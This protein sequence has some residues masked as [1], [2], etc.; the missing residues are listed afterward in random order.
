[1]YIAIMPATAA[2]DATASPEITHTFFTQFTTR[3]R[4]KDAQEETDFSHYM[5]AGYNCVS[6]KQRQKVTT[7]GNLDNVLAIWLACCYVTNRPASSS[8]AAAPL[9]M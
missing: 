4:D 7:C 2:R 5:V 6:N 8:L 1:M 9:P 3:D